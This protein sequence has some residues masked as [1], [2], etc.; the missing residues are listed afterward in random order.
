MLA[1]ACIP[2]LLLGMLEKPLKQYGFVLTIV[3]LCAL[4]SNDIK[5]AVS[6]LVY[7]AYC[8]VLIYIE[9]HLFQGKEKSAIKKH[10]V[11]GFRVIV[12]L[13]LVPLV[14]VKCT[15][16]LSISLFG[17]IGISYVTFKVI[18]VL[19]EVRDGLIKDFRCFDLLYFLL[20][21]PVFTSGPI[22]RSRDFVAQLGGPLKRE[23]YLEL[24]SSGSV[25]FLKGF[26]YSFLLASVFQWLMWFVPSLLT[27]SSVLDIVGAQVAYSFSYGLYLFFN[28]AGYSAM[29]IGVGAMVGIRV[30]QNFKAPFRSI[31]IKDFWNRWHITLSFWLRDYVF[32]R[33]SRSFIKHR[34]FSSRTTTACVCFLIEMTLMGLWHG[35]TA[36]YIA[37]GVYHGVLLAVCEL[38]QKKSSFHKAHKKDRWYR[39]ASWVITMVAVFFGFSLFSGQVCDVIMGVA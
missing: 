23:S 1:I 11:W 27:G 30:P 37:Y 38:Y 24:V 34:S 17:F 14:I 32:M 7:V 22:M 16:A 8:T 33:L 10:E 26:V 15:E 36:S 28:F 12:V 19:I 25:S 39:A 35:F 4:F 6:L 5:G 20:F 3:F 31:D 29:A 18:Q 9:L 21:F 2:A 13:A